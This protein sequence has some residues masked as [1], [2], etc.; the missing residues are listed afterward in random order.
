[1]RVDKLLE[2][3]FNIIRPG[4]T[5][6]DLVNVISESTRN[7]FPVV[8]NDGTFYGIVTMDDIRHIMF[9]PDKYDNTYVRN[10]MF[11]PE[12][13]VSIDDSMEDVAG[14]FSKSGKYVLPV[15]KGNIYKGFVSRA[16]VFSEYRKILKHFSD[17]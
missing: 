16:N 15:L 1:M 2:T 9:N 13:I 17:D 14:K 12:A 6:R 5:L 8:D 7:I 3:N 4:A 11:Y 10:L